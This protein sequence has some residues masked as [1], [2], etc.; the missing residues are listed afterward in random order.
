RSSL[1]PPPAEVRSSGT[2]PAPLS[3]P[4]V[5]PV[6]DRMVIAE[7]EDF[8][9]DGP[10]WT[11]LRH[12][13]NYFTNTFANCFLSRKAYLGAPEQA[14]HAQASID[15]RV[16]ANGTYLALVRYESARHFETQFRLRIEQGGVTKLDRLYGARDN[17]KIFAL[18]QGV[19]KEIHDVW[20]A[21]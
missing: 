1:P 2:L 20:G 15:V 3:R 4:V 5:A 17:E 9:P 16:P 14:P 10:G 13:T 21:T 8:V 12:G 11:P 7:A 6:N 19:N 18:G